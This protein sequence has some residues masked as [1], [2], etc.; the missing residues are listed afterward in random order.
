VVED[1]PNVLALTATS[2]RELGYTVFEA[3]HADGAVHHLKNGSKPDLLLTDIVMPDVNGRALAEQAAALCPQIK[4]LF[5]TGFTRN[6]IVHNGVLDADVHLL[7][8]PFSIEELS[9]KIRE[10]LQTRVQN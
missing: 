8:K 3:S 9:A 5:M 1:D 6:A 7:A 4:V 10:V 2:L